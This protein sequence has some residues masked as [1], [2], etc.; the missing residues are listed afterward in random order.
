[1][2][3]VQ[4]RI[5]A[6]LKEELRLIHAIIGT[7]P[8]NYDYDA[9][10]GFDRAQDFAERVSIVPV[11]D[12]NAST[13][14]QRVVQYQAA[15]EFAARSPDIYNLPKLHSQMLNVLGIKDA[16]EIIKSQEPPLAMDP[17]SE[18]MAII[19]NRPVQAYIHQDHQAHL[20][21]H[22]NFA[23]DP[24][25]QQMVGQS[26]NAGATQSAMA[27]HIAE[28]IAFQYRSQIEMNTGVQLPAPGQELP[29]DVE[30][31]ISKVVASA[32][33]KLLMQN[34]AAI[35]QQKAEEA[36]Q[37]PMVQIELQ[38]LANAKDEVNRKKAKDAIDAILKLRE[39]VGNDQIETARMAVDLITKAHDLQHST[40]QSGANAAVELVKTATA[41]A[42][43]RQVAAQRK[44]SNGPASSS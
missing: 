41:A 42:T 22:M 43:Q 39:L 3:G 40:V 8:G 10:E 27:A 11:S 13:M 6:A 16:S 7:L 36:M 44:K 5:H 23:Q 20:A 18:N 2:S 4:A 26:P 9:N 30:V 1:M 19:T 34:K 37:D 12:P 35:A 21:V 32:S 15:M 31:A 17:V 28:H 29:E 14:A 25:I 38:K 33:G 24:Q